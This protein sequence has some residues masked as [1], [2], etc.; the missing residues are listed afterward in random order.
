MKS[1]TRRIQYSSRSDVFRLVILSDIHLGNRHC[2]ETLLRQMVEKIAADENCYWI[3]LGDLCEWIN[4]RDSRFD[5]DELASWL[6]DEQRD[7]ARAERARLVELLAPIGPKCLAL[8]EGNHER[9]ILEH[10]ETDVYRA[11]AEGIGAEGV[12]VGA[13]GF[14]RL[15]FQR[16]TNG[17]RGT[18]WTLTLFAH[19]GFWGGRTV[20]NGANQM[21]RMAAWV[22]ADVILA[23]H[24]HR[25]RVFTME[26]LV[27]HERGAVGMRR[28]HAVSCGTFLNQPDYAERKGFPPLETGAVEIEVTPDK[29]GV[30][31]II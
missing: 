29:K 2:D 11:V 25:R 16:V 18:S 15:V 28:V 30:R 17:S 31:V 24:D 3:G 8:V 14:I 10:A 20:G 26:R 5:P 21:E 7:I 23:G 22:E 1:I 19:H 4:R 9:A 13:S 27:S 12:C 6:W